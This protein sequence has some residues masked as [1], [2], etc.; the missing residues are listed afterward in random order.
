MFCWN[1]LYHIVCLTGKKLFQRHGASSDSISD[2]SSV[3]HLD[4]SFRD[5]APIQAA[6]EDVAEVPQERPSHAEEET[7]STDQRVPESQDTE[8]SDAL[9]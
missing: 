6:D 5:T 1:V 9:R 4:E 3:G 2:T 8:S 7:V